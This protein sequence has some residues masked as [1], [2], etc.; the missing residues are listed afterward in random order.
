MWQDNKSQLAHTENPTTLYYAFSLKV[1]SN[2]RVRLLIKGATA[3]NI[4]WD[5]NFWKDDD[6]KIIMNLQFSQVFEKILWVCNFSEDNKEICEFAV[7]VKMMK[8]YC[9]FAISVKKIL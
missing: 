7:S 2:E 6:K 9:E 8:R 4:L 3:E 1:H 5:S